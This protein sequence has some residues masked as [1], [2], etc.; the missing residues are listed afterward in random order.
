[1]KRFMKCLLVCMFTLIM[2]SSSANASSLFDLL[3]PEPMP[4]KT[5]QSNIAPSFG[6]FANVMADEET[7]NKEGGKIVLYQNVSASQMEDYGKE[8]QKQGYQVLE[9]ETRG[10]T[11]AY[12]LS[13][14]TFTFTQFY[15][16]SDQSLREVYPKGTAYAQSAFPG[17]IKVKLGEK[18]K[19]QDL[20]EFTFES[21]DFLEE[22][23][24][25][26]YYKSRSYPHD[27][28]RVSDCTEERPGIFIKFNYYN[29]ST[30]A[31]DFHHR[32]LDSDDEGNSLFLPSLFYNNIDN[33][34]KYKPTYYGAVDG[35]KLN[36]HYM[37][38]GGLVSSLEEKML[39]IYF[40]LPA[41]A[42]NSTDG[43]LAMT[44]DFPNGEKYVLMLRENGV[45][46]Y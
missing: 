1:M 5:P 27:W 46:L 4:T 37:G 18:F 22:L 29:T 20:G 13:N 14:N 28:Y 19:I 2:L 30:Q 11:T 26:Y 7:E 8:L 6:D 21:M 33:S 12:T 32:Y 9:Q 44:M 17:Y 38:S 3:T 15:D 43:T 24:Y 10:N 23:V 41:G 35:T 34:Y 25:Y 31:K 36:A 16:S 40:E 39:A 42:M 45:N